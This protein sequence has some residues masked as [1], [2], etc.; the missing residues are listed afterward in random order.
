MAEDNSI[1][2]MET[3]HT[4]PPQ[5]GEMTQ[6]NKRNE[7]ADKPAMIGVSK[8]IMDNIDLTVSAHF[9]PTGTEGRDLAMTA[10]M[11]VQQ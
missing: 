9:Q 2:P 3:R 4:N 5:V 10:Q 6:R 7:E 8:D 11:Q 1:P